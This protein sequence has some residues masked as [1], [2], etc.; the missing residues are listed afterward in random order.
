[1]LSLLHCHR[2]GA[3]MSIHCT[4]Q[5]D[6]SPN[7]VAFHCLSF[8]SQ[9]FFFPAKQTG[10]RTKQSNFTVCVYVWN[11]N[12]F[13]F[14]W[15]TFSVLSSPFVYYICWASLFSRMADYFFFLS[16]I[17]YTELYNAKNIK[18][19]LDI[20]AIDYNYI[21]FSIV[22]HFSC[23]LWYRHC[24]FAGIFSSEGD[25]EVCGCASK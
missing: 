8:S 16:S 22:L 14:Y 7:Y 10:K 21:I 11:L 12:E 6:I 17:M 13:N 15:F 18:Q 25:C 2:L 23:G 5:T 24:S 19:K 20:L 1:M 3:S 9:V 4:L